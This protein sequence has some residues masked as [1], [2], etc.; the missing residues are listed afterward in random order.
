[1]EVGPLRTVEI[2]GGGNPILYPQINEL[3]TYLVNEGL[4]VGLITN[5]PLDRITQKNL[6]KLTWLRISLAYLDKENFF[7]PNNA[8]PINI[9]TIKGDLGFS[10]VWN[11]Y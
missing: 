6:D 5:N 10:Y 1:M 4:E 7:K 9:P 11:Q 3:I 2:T 8:K